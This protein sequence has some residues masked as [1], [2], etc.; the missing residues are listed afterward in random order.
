MNVFLYII[1][2]EIMSS[3]GNGMVFIFSNIYSLKVQKQL[4]MDPLRNKNCS[5]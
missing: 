3:Y 5:M 1:I 2:I 4:I